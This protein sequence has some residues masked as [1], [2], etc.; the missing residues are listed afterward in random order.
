MPDV[1]RLEMPVET[2]LELSAVIGLDDQDTEGQTTKDLIHELDGGA[3]IAGVVNLEDADTRAVVDGGEL[4]QALLS[5]WD[6]LEELHIQLQPMSGLRLLIALPGLTLP[7]MLLIGRQMPQSV[8]NQDAMH[9]GAG[10]LH[11]VEPLQIIGD[12]PGPE[13]ISLP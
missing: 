12:P 3:L 10:N 8:T 9:R 13:V 1:F 11:L 6:P 5:A 2:R 4:I 7:L